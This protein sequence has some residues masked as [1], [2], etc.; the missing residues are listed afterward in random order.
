MQEVKIKREALLA[1]VKANRDQHRKTFLLACKGFRTK[2]IQEL[3]IML[4]EA[5]DGELIRTSLSLP[6]PSD[7]TSDYDREIRML[8]MCDDPV[9]ELSAHEFDM[10]V[11]DNWNWKAHESNVTAMYC[12]GTDFVNEG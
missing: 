8:E 6:T 3:D 4:K 1:A 5:Q 9:V 11:M 7:H 2:A 12:S 10:Y